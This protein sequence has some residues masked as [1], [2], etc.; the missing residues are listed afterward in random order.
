[1]IRISSGTIAELMRASPRTSLFLTCFLL[2]TSSL[3]ANAIEE[4][5]QLRPIPDFRVDG[6]EAAVQEQLG[7]I[8]SELDRVQ[9]DP[10]A[11]PRQQAEAYGA[12]GQIL[13]SYE[14]FEGAEDC[15][16]NARTLAPDEFRWSY[17]LG[18][19]LR[20]QGRWDDSMEAFRAALFIRPESIPALVHLGEI[21]LQISDSDRAEGYFSNALALD[22][23]LAAAH[24]GLGQARLSRREYGAAIAHLEAALAH[25]PQ[26]DLIHY[27]LGMA[28]R[29]AGDLQLAQHHLNR[30][31]TVGIRPEDPLM[32][33]LH[34]LG[35]GE[36][37]AMLRGRRAYHAGRYDDAVVE[38]RRA[39]AAAPN[40]SRSRTN[41][42]SALAKI[43]RVEEAMNEFQK[44]LELNPAGA[45][46]ARYNLAALM[47]HAGRPAEAI[48]LLRTV[49][50]RHPSDRLARVDL[51]RAL[52]LAGETGKALEIL[53]PAVAAQ[54]PDV[55]ASL[56]E[57]DLL[58]KLDQ[59]ASAR[60]RLES[61]RQNHPQDLRALH[62]LA[63]LMATATDPRVKDPA[64]ALNLAMRAFDASPTLQHA[65]AVFLA[66]FQGGECQQAVKWLQDILRAQLPEDDRMRLKQV[67]AAAKRD[68]RCHE[69][70]LK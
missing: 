64:R 31:G 19:V 46:S 2:A 8:R 14:L 69:Q 57:V 50:S 29:G 22:E 62:R 30:S 59:Q 5:P 43:G 16:H 45:D 41:L 56:L 3:L 7:A 32:D 70:N 18:V 26:A 40:S 15:Y 48:P 10:G 68:P 54:P 65:E 13:H 39:V 20:R 28:Y 23:S 24:L 63:V 49:V 36:V 1:M 44:A 12:L 25:A 60:E 34:S 38:F 27:S 33:E 42:A 37:F 6:L 4:G 67:L 58:L 47:L 51:A 35:T 66:L 53:R 21:C 55:D 11:T 9:N 52:G 17:Y 61:L